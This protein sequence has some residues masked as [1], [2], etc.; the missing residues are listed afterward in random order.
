LPGAALR[1]VSPVEPFD[2]APLRARGSVSHP[3]CARG[4]PG[5]S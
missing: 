1:V 4:L 3:R 5:N 2:H